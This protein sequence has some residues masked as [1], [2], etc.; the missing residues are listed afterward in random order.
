[1][2]ILRFLTIALVAAGAAACDNTSIPEG[3]AGSYTLSVVGTEDPPVWA[4]WNGAQGGG[5]QLMSARLTL[6]DNGALEAA[7]RY[8][9]VGS[10]GAGAEQTLT[11]TGTWTEQGDRVTL[12]MASAG[13]FALEPEL[14]VASNRRIEALV[15]LQLP[16]YVGYGWVPMPATFTR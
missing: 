9:D 15:G 1:M 8:R 11:L 5:H 13:V 10:E 7:F 6:R 4:N 3:V 2:R 16:A 14:V 12:Q